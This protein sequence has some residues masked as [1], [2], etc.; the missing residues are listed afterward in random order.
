[1]GWTIVQ[2]KNE[3]IKAR[4]EVHHGI[5]SS[6]FAFAQVN[7]AVKQPLQ[8][9]DLLTLPKLFSFLQEVERDGDN[10]FFFI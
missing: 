7:T 3:H 9:E 2:P 4:K 5:E 8:D 6:N 1:M 10:A